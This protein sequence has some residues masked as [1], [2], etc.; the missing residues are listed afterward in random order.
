MFNTQTINRIIFSY[1]IT[2]FSLTMVFKFFFS[3]HN[4]IHRVTNY[5]A[6]KNK[7]NKTRQHRTN[8]PKQTEK[9]I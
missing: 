6:I 4:K 3:N 5:L 1:G 8:K 9:K 7:I 2:P